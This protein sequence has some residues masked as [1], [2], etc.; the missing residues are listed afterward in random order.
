MDEK[1][2][3]AHARLLTRVWLRGLYWGVA[4]GAIITV[5]SFIIWAV[6]FVDPGY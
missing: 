2:F 1:S 6:V 3:E 5:L 4:C